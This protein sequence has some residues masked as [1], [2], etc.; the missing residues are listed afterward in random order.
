MHTDI[1]Q[2]SANQDMDAFD[3]SFKKC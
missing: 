1:T 2:P 3:T